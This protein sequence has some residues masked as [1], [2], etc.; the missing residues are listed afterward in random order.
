MTVNLNDR[1]LQVW[2]RNFMSIDLY[3]PRF[4]IQKLNYIHHNPCL[5]K[6]EQVTDPVN[7]TYSSAKFYH[8]LENS[9]DLLE[10]FDQI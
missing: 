9:F 2:K 7:Y 3:T 5:P 1:K 8:D 4:V 10:H 6:W